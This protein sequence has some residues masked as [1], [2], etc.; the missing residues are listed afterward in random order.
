MALAADSLYWYLHAHRKVIKKSNFHSGGVRSDLDDETDSGALSAH[1]EKAC[2]GVKERAGGGGG[3]GGVLHLGSFLSQ[4]T[5]ASAP[6]QLPPCAH[7]AS[8]ISPP[9][10]LS[11]SLF[12]ARAAATATAKLPLSIYAHYFCGC[13]CDFLFRRVHRR[14]QT[15]DAFNS[16]APHQIK[17]RVCRCWRFPLLLILSLR[18]L[19]P[20]C[21][22][23]LLFPDAALR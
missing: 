21:D 14:L 23:C 4:V 7:A 10:H 13:A 5:S 6:L 17:F 16:R 18:R 8:L 11:L 9:N 1:I 19:P 2:G 3:G 22:T 12:L 20:K 15:R